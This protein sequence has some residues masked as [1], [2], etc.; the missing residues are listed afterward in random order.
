MRALV[1]VLLSLVHASFLLAASPRVTVERV[2]PPSIDLRGARSVA[3]IH[4]VGDSDTVHAFV[5]NF[6]DQLNHTGFFEARDA[7]DSSGPADAYLAV[8]TF[9]CETFVREGTGRRPAWVDAVCTARV[10][11]RARDMKR[12]SSFYG[13][14]EGSDEES[15]TALRQA[16]RYAAIDA[17]ERILPRRVREH[18]PLDDRAPAF[19][20]GMG[21]IESGH[22]R[23]AR[24]EWEAALRQHP[25]SAALHANLAAVCEAL[26]D[27]KAAEA[28][29]KAARALRK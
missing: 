17:A 22:L 15:D 28:H 2:L 12:V 16:A 5:E 27:R 18:I 10:D 21:L 3:L 11:V 29:A 24:A 1:A 19:A 13:K 14:G 4:A 8:E 6:I 7:R 9:Q 25:R 23:E 26:G 20:E